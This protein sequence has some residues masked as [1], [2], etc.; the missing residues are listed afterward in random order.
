M[1]WIELVALVLTAVAALAA[2]V[3]L[4]IAFFN[5]RDMVLAKLPKIQLFNSGGGYHFRLNT[6][7]N[8]I[9]WKVIKVEV[10]DSN[11]RKECLAQDLMVK[12]DE[13]TTKYVR[14]GWRDFCEYPEGASD[15]APLWVHP[16]CYKASLSFICSVPSRKRK[17]V[18]YK[19]VR[20]EQL[21]SDMDPI[22]RSLMKG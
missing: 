19:F 13:R 20:G 16:N 6:D 8:S 17:R 18:P 22:L 10:V 5:R 15:F 9:G 14:S 1:I 3:G 4:V 21:P 2:T 11:Y 7:H 12:E